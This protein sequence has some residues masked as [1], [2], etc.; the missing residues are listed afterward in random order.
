MNLTYVNGKFELL[1]PKGETYRAVLFYESLAQND[2]GK[3]IDNILTEREPCAVI[4]D[5]NNVNKSIQSG[6]M[7]LE[8]SISKAGAVVSI[9]AQGTVYPFL[10]RA[11][12]TREYGINCNGYHS[13]RFDNV[14]SLIAFAKQ[15]HPKSAKGANL[16]K[17]KR[18]I[19]LSADG[20]R[21]TKTEIIPGSSPS[22]DLGIDW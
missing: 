17:D 20:W 21:E 18:V 22:F 8:P 2:A 16:W 9:N 11:G 3:S 13:I 14:E 5:M 12:T 10:I 7:G 6:K 15:Y 19:R 1:A 4:P